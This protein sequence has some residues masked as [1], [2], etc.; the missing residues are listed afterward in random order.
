MASRTDHHAARSVEAEQAERRLLERA[1]AGDEASFE[2]LARPQLGGWIR[3]ARAVGGD[4]AESEDVVFHVLQKLWERIRTQR[5]VVQ[6]FGAYGARMIANEAMDRVR[7]RGRALRRDE[8]GGPLIHAP[9]PCDPLHTVMERE[10]RAALDGALAALKADDQ[11]IL[12]LQL[13]HGM[14]FLDIARHLSGAG[15]T[16]TE[17]WARKRYQRAREHLRRQAARIISGTGHEQRGP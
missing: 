5:L 8:A 7:S 14:P 9:R 10:T 6:D 3:T 1:A 11:L 4:F 2:A 12:E 17:S 15:A 16:R 13:H